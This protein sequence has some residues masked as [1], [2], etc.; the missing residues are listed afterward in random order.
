[1]VDF[2]S[3]IEFAKKI[4]KN[5]VPYSIYPGAVAI[6]AALNLSPKEYSEYNYQDLLNLYSRIDKIKKASSMDIYSVSSSAGAVVSKSNTAT[7]QKQK[8]ESQ[9]RQITDDALAHA[10][11]IHEQPIDLEKEALEFESISQ[12]EK[13]KVTSNEHAG[14]H[15]VNLD[16]AE[17]KK[18]EEIDFDISPSDYVKSIP[19]EP[20]K[21]DVSVTAQ[22][23]AQVIPPV[24]Q[25][26]A[27]EDALKKFD[28]IEEKINT[29]LGGEYDETKL[30]RKM[31]ELTKE[32]FKE[33]STQ[34]REEIKQEITIL[35]NMLLKGVPVSTA[36]DAKKKSAKKTLESGARLQLFTTLVN[37]QMTEMSDTKDQIVDS[38][39]KKTL[40]IKTKYDEASARIPSEDSQRK[41]QLYEKYVFMLSS[42]LDKLP[43]ISKRYQDYVTQKH[44]AEMEK[45][46]ETCSSGESDL[47]KKAEERINGINQIYASEFNVISG[48][49]K[50]EINGLID[51]AGGEVFEETKPTESKQASKVQQIVKEVN[52]TDEGTLLYFLHSK[53][54]ESYQQYERKHLS[55]Q[56]AI[57]R[58]KALMA[59]EKGLSDDM[60]KRYFE[61]ED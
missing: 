60:V 58:A 28:Q 1:M 33:K 47:M 3:T 59:K 37:T 29:A 23:S 6:E 17:E 56:E 41:K 2:D 9:V 40:Q 4:E 50:K 15:S 44:L 54:F 38:F 26:K 53:D 12:D 43:D 55:K 19:D 8:I 39:K 30:K 20:S 7:L 57:F 11:E 42:L 21:P 5:A 27:E 45:L 32:L 31:L 22:K 14:I 52:E 34:R 61:S 10:K 13:E 46:K 48:I 49:I 16:F 25:E 18:P 24:L 36:K 35:K 51:S